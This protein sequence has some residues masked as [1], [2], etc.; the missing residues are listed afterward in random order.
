MHAF[1]EFGETCRKSR[2]YEICIFIRFFL[3]SF[4]PALRFKTDY[5]GGI[6]GLRDYEDL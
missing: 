2:I 6:Q 4:S 1:C 3:H 5:Q